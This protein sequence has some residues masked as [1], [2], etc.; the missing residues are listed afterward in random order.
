RRLTF[1]YPDSQEK[2]LRGIDLT[3]EPGRTLGIVG[4][5]GS[6][7]TT[8]MKLL[9]RLYDPPAGAIRIGQMDIRDL[10]LESLR[11]GIAYVPQDGFL[12]STTIQDNIA[13]YKRDAET[14]AVTQAAKQAQIYHNIK[15]FPEQFDT[16][17]GQRGV[18]LSGGQRQ[19]TSLARGLI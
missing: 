13:F 8:L 5:T 14:E 15:A 12:F 11:S 1:A 16:K 7:K 17:L 19:R 10:T 2:A 6:G 4:R 18:T 3:I 9:L